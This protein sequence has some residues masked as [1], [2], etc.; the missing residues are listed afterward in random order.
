VLSTR[1]VPPFAIAIPMFLMF[2]DLRLLDSLTGLVLAHTVF[3]LPFAMWILQSGF[4]ELSP[5][6]E[7]A[8][9]IDGCSR[10]GV[11]WHVALPLMKP[12]ILCAAIFTLFLSWNEFLFALLL[13]VS[14]ART[15][16]LLVT[17]FLTD[18]SMEWGNIAAVSLVASLPVVLFLLF[19]QRYLVQGL[20]AGAVK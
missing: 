11:F 5:E 13:T 19:A 18:R 1:F 12:S 15:V 2:R 4:D 17:Q 14:Q 7:E 6:I 8:G 9:L 3:A 20:T 16:P 10:L